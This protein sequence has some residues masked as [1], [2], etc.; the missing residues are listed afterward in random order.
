[1]RCELTTE[2]AV[3]RVTVFA[4]LAFLERRPELGLLCR[5]ARDHGRSI[6]TSVVQSALP[7]L[8]DAGATNVIAWCKMIGLCDARGGLT[9]LGED[10]A[11]SDEAPVPEQG[12]YGLWLAQH[13]VFGRRVLSVERLASNRDHRFEAI[14]TLAMEPDRGK[15]F[16]SVVNAK[17]RFIVRDLPSNHGQPGGLPVATKA[18][19]RFRWALEFDQARDQWQLDGVV[20]APNTNGKAAMVPIRHD[21]ES[22]GLDLWQ[23]VATWATGPLAAVGRWQQAQR[24]L[25]VSFDGLADG[26]FESFRKSLALRKVEVPGKGT[27]QDVTLTDL[28]IGPASAQ[29][30]Q[31]WALARFD[32]HLAAN[33]GY[34]SRA[35]VRAQFAQ[36]TEDTPLEAFAPT[37]PS[38]DDLLAQACKDPQRLWSLAAPVDLSPFTLAADELGP[39]RIGAPGLV[40]VDA[41][42]GAVR[43]PYQAGWPMRKLV[44]SLLAGHVPARVLLCDRYVRGEDNLKMLQLLVAALRA[45]APSV[46]VDVWSE[47]DA[48]DYKKIRQLTGTAPRSY[49]DEFGRDVPHDRYFLV[50]HASSPGFGWQMSNSPLHARLDVDDGGPDTRLR[51]K[52][53]TATRVQAHEIASAFRNWL[54]GGAR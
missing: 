30:A 34:R 6:T 14:E 1:M 47:G 20:E 28:P 16:R 46:I 43:V 50:R 40:A 33:P 53:L 41:P 7:G 8:P 12:V 10:V 54:T 38:H 19:C 44:E 24:R 11:Q 52:D 3:T 5:T 23:L 36:L 25:A 31:R 39:M 27:Y 15:V 35:A 51:W 32:R 22:D 45:V 37:L 29:D 42:E 13:P 4:E 9:A 21:P 49:R 48:A 18:V 2:I 17:D 26:E